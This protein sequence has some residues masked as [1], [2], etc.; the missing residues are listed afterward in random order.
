M[1]DKLCMAQELI[2]S[3]DY[4]E[5]VAILQQLI[6][7][8]I[9]ELENYWYLGLV[10]LLQGNRELAE[11]IWIS[12]LLLEKPLPF[13]QFQQALI[14]FLEGLFPEYLNQDKFIEARTLLD[15][16]HSLDE[17]Y[18]NLELQA[19]VVERLKS[20]CLQGLD[21]IK[22]R[23]Y[24]EA[25]KIFKNILT[26]DDKDEQTWLNL[27]L[28]YVETKTWERAYEVTMQLLEL[29]DQE[30]RYHF[31][32]GEISFQSGN[33]VNAIKGYRS[34][35][36]LGYENKQE[37]Y[38]HVCECYAALGKHRA[39]V[40]LARVGILKY[41]D[42]LKF[43]HLYQSIL[44][45]VYKNQAEIK[46]YRQRFAKLLR[47]YI[48]KAHA[49]LAIEEQRQ[50]VADSHFL[51]NFYL[52]Y[53]GYNDKILLKSLGNFS[54]LIV[55]NVYS[56][57]QNYS[58]H[59]SQ[60]IKSKK[61]IKIGYISAKVRQKLSILSEGWL[62][63]TDK[64][65]YEIY[66]Y[67]LDSGLIANEEDLEYDL[68]K[69]ANHYWQFSEKG[70]REITDRVLGDQLDILIFPDI[71]MD[72]ITSFIA[73][74][75]LAPVQCTT[76][77]HPITSGLPTIDYF[78][79]SD[80]MEPANG[81][82]HYTEKLVRLPNLGVYLTY[83]RQSDMTVSRSEL[84][85]SPDQMLYFCC[86]SWQK[87]LPQFDYLFPEIAT[88]NPNALFVFIEPSTQTR[89]YAD[90]FV[91]RLVKIFQEYNLDFER[92]CKIFSRIS[93]EKYLAVMREMDIFLDS[94]GWSGGI[95][96]MHAL[97]CGLPVVTCPGK[98]MRARHSYALLHRIG[99][100]ETIAQDEKDYIDIA[101]KLG[102]N[103][104]YR[105]GIRDQ[106]NAH[107]HKIFEDDECISALE[108]FFETVVKPKNNSD[109][110][111]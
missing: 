79:S 75:R 59:N 13:D 61:K 71:G 14:G 105:Q 80:L 108:D 107:K 57:N 16:I 31:L 1:K 9:D 94:F 17:T 73:A 19:I 62:R 28:L 5:A 55:K 46:Y 87:Y 24:E 15:V 99:M 26:I 65:R 84:G 89:Y 40:R 110:I 106:I 33:H 47:Q 86:Q 58:A 36:K 32:V 101:V 44:P 22:N 37:I 72:P 51:S 25:E 27:C 41:P 30:P 92:H 95:T 38:Y 76:W 6:E 111:I 3:K 90:I 35:H 39:A 103:H 8:E 45:V 104:E 83:P 11:E 88:K 100:L 54:D 78:L 21:A 48:D 4:E 93:H 23:Q 91:K 82:S 10:H 97:N 50:M 7:S 96:T 109:S 34:A 42:N 64:N 68:K 2:K 81:E 60:F 67:N 43:F 18:I 63:K 12:V 85:F 102:V 49:K 52:S 66:V 98:L 20:L 69:F 56:Q 74:F 29:N 77:A 53:Q 70:Y